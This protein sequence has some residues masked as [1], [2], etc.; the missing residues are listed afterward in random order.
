MLVIL[1]AF[2]DF[3]RIMKV[4]GVFTPMIIVA[5]TI[6]TIYSLATPHPGIAELNAAATQVTRRCPTCGS[7]RSTTSRCVSSTASRWPSCWVVRCCA[8][9]R[10]AAPGAS[11]GTIIALVIGA[12][13]LC[14]YLNMVASGT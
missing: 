13:A 12:D 1:T 14:L 4:I 2:L 11:A 6:L 5:I 7:P 3:D 9:A 8:S 10:P